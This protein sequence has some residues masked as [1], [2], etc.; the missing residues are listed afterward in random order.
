M[1]AGPGIG[2]G[3]DFCLRL[4][5]ELLEAV[6]LAKESGM[7]LIC[8]GEVEAVGGCATGRGSGMALFGC[9]ERRVVEGMCR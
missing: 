9:S 1:Q 4:R 2:N 7:A 3:A 5:V 6:Q 8:Y